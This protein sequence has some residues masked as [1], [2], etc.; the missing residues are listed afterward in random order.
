M[1]KKIVLGSMVLQSFVVHLKNNK[2]LKVSRSKTWK[3]YV[4]GKSVSEDMDAHKYMMDL[5][6]EFIKGRS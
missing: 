2:D 5:W 1:K 3:S 6:D 4:D